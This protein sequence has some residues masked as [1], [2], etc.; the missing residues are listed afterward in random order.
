MTADADTIEIHLRTADQLFN[1]LDP[2]PFRERDL[3]DKAERY[4]VGSA[5]ELKVKGPLRLTVTL[6][7]E[8]CASPFAQHVPEA[9][10]NYFT[11][12]AGLL[13]QDLRE[14]LRNGWRFLSIGLVV[15][16]LCF[17][18][19]RALNLPPDASPLMRLAEQSLVILGWVA[20]WRPI[21][22]FLYEWLPLYRQIKLYDRIAEA[23]VK[24][25]PI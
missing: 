22:I 10:N 9:I 8:A 19:I 23:Q 16:A 5:R 11:Y 7:R 13:R 2:S 14:L 6:P 25:L 12:R 18:A 3:D 21:E 4:I 17:T 20:N 24:L 1:L 15:L